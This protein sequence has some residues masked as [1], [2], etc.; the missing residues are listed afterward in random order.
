M[1]DGGMA[2][3][4]CLSQRS[5]AFTTGSLDLFAQ[6]W[7]T[8]RFYT[9]RKTLKTSGANSERVANPPLMS[10]KSSAT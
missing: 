1:W 10:L 5:F 8:R 6:Y 3:A 2:N 4:G 7:P 9:I